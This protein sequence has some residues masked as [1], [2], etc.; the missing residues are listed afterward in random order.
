MKRAPNN[1]KAS[2]N[3]HVEI[4]CV[5]LNLFNNRLNNTDSSFFDGAVVPN[6]PA[7]R[8]LMYRAD[9][10]RSITNGNIMTIKKRFLLFGG[11]TSMLMLG[12]L[13]ACNSQPQAVDPEDSDE[14]HYHEKSFSWDDGSS[15]EVLAKTTSLQTRFNST[16]EMEQ[17]VIA[18]DADL[19]RPGA[20]DSLWKPIDYACDELLLAL[21]NKYG[22]IRI[23]DSTVLNEP[24]LKSNCRYIGEDPALMKLSKSSET[25]YP[26]EAIDRQY[27]Y[28]MIGNSWDNFNAVVYK[29]TGGETQFKK[30]R[31]K[32]GIS[33]WYD[34]DATRIG[35]RIYVVDCPVSR[36]S[37]CAIRT[38]PHNSNSNTDYASYR[39]YAIG[40]TGGLRVGEAV[41]STHSVD[42]AGLQ[43]RAI[44]SS[45]L[46][47]SMTI[48][49][50]TTYSYVTW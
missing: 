30:D 31:K 29:S 11:F 32:L 49:N 35:V 27:P 40:I 16:E 7:S 34:T 39:D 33:G 23:G 1:T 12:L 36:A 41:I 47:A 45:G 13:T 37:F 20:S 44:S 5:P 15:K 6:I 8:L 26:R 4:F 50:P 42:H 17:A 46:S 19:K 3:F 14:D 24:L 9:Q 43:F 25:V 28:K 2:T 18:L 10:C 21:W 38:S 22:T 48:S